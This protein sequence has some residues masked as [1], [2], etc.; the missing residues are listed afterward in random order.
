[1]EVRRRNIM[2]YFG[3]FWVFR[4]SLP[5]ET[6]LT[7]FSFTEQ[8]II[9]LFHSESDIQKALPFVVMV[10]GLKV[11]LDLGG[12]AWFCGTHDLSII[13]VWSRSSWLLER[14]QLWFLRVIWPCGCATLGQP[15]ALSGSRAFCSAPVQWV[16]QGW[17][18]HCPTQ[19]SNRCLNANVFNTRVGELETR[20]KSVMQWG[21]YWVSV[22]D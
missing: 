6:T 12:E 3:W 5:L 15:R 10:W 19:S 14:N 18:W 2:N 16:L 17:G 22:E 11:D 9:S 13:C 8:K 4:F 20:L 7:K 21:H 1:M